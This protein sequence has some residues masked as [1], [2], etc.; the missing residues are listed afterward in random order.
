MNFL[1]A[2]DRVD[3]D[4]ILFILC[5][6]GTG[7]NSST[8][9]IYIS[10][11]FTIMCRVLQGCFLSVLLYIVAAEVFGIFIDANTRIKTVQIGDR[12]IK[13]VNF[14]DDFTIF[15]RTLTTELYV[16]VMSRTRFRVNP[17]SIVV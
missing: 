17:Q 4:F 7:T 2:F 16:L 12:K 5:K 11:P 9:F 10:E 8:K 15:L 6:F 13:I 3:R 14:A 1:K